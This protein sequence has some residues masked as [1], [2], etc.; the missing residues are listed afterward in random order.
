MDNPKEIQKYPQ[1]LLNT[2][3]IFIYLQGCTVKCVI[4]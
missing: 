1:Y 4:L 2:G 3:G